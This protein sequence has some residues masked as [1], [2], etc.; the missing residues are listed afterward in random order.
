MTLS[1]GGPKTKRQTGKRFNYPSTPVSAPASTVRLLRPWPSPVLR[2][3]FR[4]VLAIVLG[5][6]R[7]LAWR[8]RSGPSAC[9]LEG[10]ST[11]VGPKQSCR[12]SRL[13]KAATLPAAVEAR[14]LR[15]A[16]EE[17]HLF[18]FQSTQ[19]HP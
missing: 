3:R 19:H 7:T 10:K 6:A 18:A 9:Y 11:S 14:C 8:R 5:P 1:F 12:L 2:D 15:A 17:F 4:L 13:S 16:R